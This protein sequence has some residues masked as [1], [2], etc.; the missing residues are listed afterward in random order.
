MMLAAG[1]VSLLLTPIGNA[2]SRHNERRADRFALDADA[3]P[4]RLHLRDAPSRRAEP[5]RRESVPTP[6]LWFF[7]THPTIDERI[8]AARVRHC[9]VRC[10]SSAEQA[11]CRCGGI[12]CP[13]CVDSSLLRRSSRSRFPHPWR[14]SRGRHRAR[15][16][17]HAERG[18]RLQF[19]RRL[20][21]R[22]LQAD[23]GLLEDARHA[24]PTAWR[25]TTWGRPPRGGRSGWRSSR[26]RRTT[27]SWRDT[28]TSRGA[29]AL[30]EGLTDDQA[31]ALAKEGK[32]VVWIDGGLHATET[33]G[34][35]QLGA[36]GLR[37]GQPRR[38]GDAR[39]SSTTASSCS[40]TPI[41]TATISSPTGTCATPNPEQRSLGEPAAAL[42][43]VHRPRQQP[44]LLR[45]DAARDR[46]H[47]SRALPRVAAADSL[48][49]PPERSGRARS[50]GRRRSAIPTTTISIRC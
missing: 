32:A 4:R 41:R 50:C 28:A 16:H 46:E 10:A 35:Q 22:Q 7:H 23:R 34:A 19:R 17:H 37:D 21:A 18:A 12:I 9:G 11:E 49:P 43:E 45:L 31:R 5:C 6:V 14:S 20:P 1:A 47:Q 38:R 48:Q 29:L 33:L 44:R 30:A 26:R 27:R 36:D 25:S 42:P 15:S 3:P 24:S 13:P 40:F 8:A 2:W 39:D